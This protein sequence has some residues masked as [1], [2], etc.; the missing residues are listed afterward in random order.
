MRQADR[1]ART[2]PVEVEVAN[3]EGALAGGMFA[4]VTVP[5]GAPH[6]TV[7]VPKDAVVERDG[8]SHVGVVVPGHQGGTA[9][10]LVPVTVGMAV[11]H[12]IAITSGNIRP[13]TSVITRGTERILPFPAPI[14]I[15]D[16][17]GTP[18]ASPLDDRKS[19]SVEGT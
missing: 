13:G 2:F 12:R 18:V 19:A 7:A 17:M 10:V 15:V 11:G 8:I 4:K 3:P 14:E 9:G 1:T 6:R 16:E 5:A